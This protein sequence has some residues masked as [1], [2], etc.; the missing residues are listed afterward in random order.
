MP[1]ARLLVE[2]VA[3]PPVS[4][5]GPSRVLPSEKVTVPVGVAVVPP[6]VDVMVAVKVTDWPTGAGFKDEASKVASVAR[7]TTWLNTV[8]VREWKLESPL[9]CA[10]ML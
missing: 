7:V 2:N 6:D 5:V 4:G 1:S 9:Y 10:V 8:E 3:T